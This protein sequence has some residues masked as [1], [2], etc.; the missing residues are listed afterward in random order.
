MAPAKLSSSSIATDPI[1]QRPLCARCWTEISRTDREKGKRRSASKKSC[2][3]FVPFEEMV[4]SDRKL[5]NVSRCGHF[6]LS[7]FS[8]SSL[9]GE[10]SN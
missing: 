8:P 10:L 7:F 6:F 4:K 2:E 9:L 5:V 3:P 1:S